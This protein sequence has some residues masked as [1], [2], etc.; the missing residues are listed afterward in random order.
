MVIV[1]K[2]AA[3]VLVASALLLAAPS[4]F[5]TTRYVAKSG[6]DG[7]DC[8]K[9]A[10]P[11]ATITHAIE[12]MA[13]GDELVIG[14]GT[15]AE[16]VWKMPSGTAAA[17]TTIR[18][19]HDFGVLIDGSNFPNTYQPGI[20]VA[21]NSYVQVRGIRV[22]MNQKN[23]NNEP[24]QV[25]TSDHVKIQRCM[26]SYGPVTGNAASI[27]V[28]PASH[29]VLIE[30]CYAF[31]GARYQFIVYQSQH[32]VVRR[33]VARNDYWNGDLQCAGFTNY[34]SNSTSWQ[35]NI[36]LDADTKDCSGKMYGGF[37]NENKTDFEPDTTETFKGNIVLNVQAFFA[38]DYDYAVS[39]THDLE[40]MI[41]WGSAG[42]YYGDQGDGVP[43]T[44]HARHFT[45][46]AITGQYDGPN[47][48]AAFGT[49]AS[50]FGKVTNTFDSSV[51]WKNASLGVA[52]Y[53]VSD[54]DV[55]FGNGANYGG[56]HAA[57]PGAHDVTTTDPTTSLKYLPRIEPGSPLATAG[58]D[59]GRAG[60]EV[61]YKIGATGSLD[62]DP[63]WDQPTTEPLWPWPNEDQIKT[64]MAAYDGP[65][66]KG[67][68]GFAT[69]NSLDGS[70]QTLTKYIWE[71]LGNPIPKDIYANAPD[72]GTPPVFGNVPAGNNGSP[73]GGGG[74]GDSGC[75][76][77]AAGEGTG[78]L[79]AGAIGFGLVLSLL[80]RRRTRAS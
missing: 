67:A 7:S 12:V 53:T 58:K 16:P 33:N 19:E 3:G 17:Y 72:G 54:Y 9:Q 1:G 21:Q 49:G 39:G 5:A 35:N 40:D 59:G 78:S 64:D 30:E 14:D 4:A 50:V 13:G 29:H 51:F 25:S 61:L 48:G 18:A 76:C 15:Y 38:G 23:E 20:A 70:P 68:R 46:G 24:I 34:D 44:I 79:F 73:N 47:G 74:G 63:G 27:D 6:N 69:G 71:Y 41:I 26:G 36:I 77:R 11:C 10:T 55:F 56:A 2:S 75:G 43:G 65:G 31:G 32:V 62:G 8:T 80:R 66:G 22:K 52:D 28:G 60:A 45:V 37:F 42:G 57:T